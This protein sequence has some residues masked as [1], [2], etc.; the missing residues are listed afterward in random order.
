MEE[1]KNSYKA[2]ANYVLVHD[3]LEMD[4]LKENI[5]DNLSRMS[6][7]TQVYKQRVKKTSERK[8]KKK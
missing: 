7:L 3:K 6:G 5:L 2:G 4:F 1:A 8:S